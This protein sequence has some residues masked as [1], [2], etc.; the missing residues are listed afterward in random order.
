MLIEFRMT[1]NLINKR[2]G[3]ELDTIAL[4]IDFKTDSHKTGSQTRNSDTKHAILQF[5]SLG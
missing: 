3:Y 4:Y 1:Q 5:C 2:E